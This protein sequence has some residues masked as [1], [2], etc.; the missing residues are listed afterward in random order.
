MDNNLHNSEKLVRYIDNELN[1]AE[2][3]ALQLELETNISLQQELNNLLLIK[4]VIKNYGIVQKVNV[5]HKTM[6]QDLAIDIH[7]TK[8]VVRKL[9]KMIISIAASIIIIMGIFGV[10]KYLTISSNN[11]YE[12][13]YTTYQV[14]VMRGT[15]AESAIAKAY[16]EKRYDSIIA[17]YKQMKEPTINEQFLTAQS[18]LNKADYHNAIT[19]LN[20]I[21]KKNKSAHSSVLNDESEYYVALGHLKNKETAKA[22]PLF[23]KIYHDK[24]HLYHNKIDRWYLAKIQLLARKN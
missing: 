19:L 14:A 15:T 22:L 23:D 21:I 24:D 5:I 16:S 20:D 8:A 9:P 12:E 13:K 2:V 7:P 10:Y 3:A 11:L 1:E 6:M 17:L 18:Y 4:G